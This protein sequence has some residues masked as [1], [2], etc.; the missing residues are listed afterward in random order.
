M[1]AGSWRILVGDDAHQLDEAVR[2]DPEHA[3]EP[4]FI[5]ALRAKGVFAEMP[6]PN[7]QGG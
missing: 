6:T 4:E 5:E 3:Y 1:R 2:A 7:G